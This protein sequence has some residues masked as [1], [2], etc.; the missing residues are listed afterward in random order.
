MGA[1]ESSTWR[2]LKDDRRAG[3][4]IEL[5][6]RPSDGDGAGAGRVPATTGARAAARQPEEM[7]YKVY[8]RRWF[9]LVQLTLL[10][11]IVSWDVSG[12]VPH[13]TGRPLRQRGGF[14]R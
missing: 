9:G 5:S 1:A 10:N 13:R 6:S 7:E 3:A 2:E 4:G 8:R 12:T 11:I 14:D